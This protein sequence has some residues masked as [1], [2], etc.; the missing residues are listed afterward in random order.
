MSGLAQSLA[1]RSS[2]RIN[3]LLRGIF[4]TGGKDSGALSEGGALHKQQ[5][6]SRQNINFYKYILEPPDQ[7]R[8]KSA[9]GTA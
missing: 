9:N 1:I 2:D 4:R 8:A 7:N 6:S 3:R 5:K